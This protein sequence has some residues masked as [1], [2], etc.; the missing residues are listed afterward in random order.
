MRPTSRRTR[1]D[2][3]L[4][5]VP[6]PAYAMRTST[7]ADAARHPKTRP[8]HRPVSPS[9]P[10]RE[11]RIAKELADTPVRAWQLHILDLILGFAPVPQN[12]NRS[13]RHLP[14]RTIQG[15]QAFIGWS[16]IDPRKRRAGTLETLPSYQ[17]GGY[18]RRLRLRKKM[19]LVD[20][21]RYTGLS[22]SLLSQLETKRKAFPTLALARIPMVFDINLDRFFADRAARKTFASS[23]PAPFVVT[24]QSG[25]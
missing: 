19:A 2:T 16:R 21:G 8:S 1:S 17:L 22:T 6:P 14:L 10:S 13:P 12:P 11:H 23:A 4:R 25:P 3:C 20:L 18:L 5:R 15:P 24:A 7:R 9:H